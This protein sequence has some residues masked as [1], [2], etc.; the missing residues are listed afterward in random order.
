MADPKDLHQLGTKINTE[1]LARL[2]EK[3][4]VGIN[5]PLAQRMQRAIN[6]RQQE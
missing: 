1:T 6:A 3:R 4:E 2:R 5:G